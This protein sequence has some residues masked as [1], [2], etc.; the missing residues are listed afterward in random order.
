MRFSEAIGLTKYPE[1]TDNAAD[2]LS[3]HAELFLRGGGTLTLTDWAMMVAD[4]REAFT[5]AG[6][7]IRLESITLA[8]MASSSPLAAADI[9]KHIDGGDLKIRLV[10]DDFMDKLES[11]YK[12]DFG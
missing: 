12:A 3:A 7:R 11:K 1:L 4:E 8:G 6:E 5:D 9:Y 10:L 2:V